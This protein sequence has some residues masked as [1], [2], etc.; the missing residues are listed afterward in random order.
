MQTITDHLKARHLD[1]KLHRP[2]IDEANQVVTFW[3]WSLCGA[4]V[5]F[6]QYNPDGSKKVD[7]HPRNGKYFTYRKYPAVTVW[8]VESLQFGGPV[9]LAEGLF[10]AA[11][12]TKLKR[13]ALAALSNDPDPGLKNLLKCLNRPVVA[14]CDNDKAGKKL[15]KF[16]DWVEVMTEKDLGDSSDEQVVELL[17]R[18]K[19]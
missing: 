12:L 7:N 6:H 10:D 13:P 9:F 14:I 2:V 15:A 1:L 19:K 8:G 3:L 11:R 17:N 5:G 4:L 18:W 16:G